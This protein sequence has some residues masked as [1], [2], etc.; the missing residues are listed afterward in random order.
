[1]S[2]DQPPYGPPQG[3]GQDPK[4]GP[5]WGPPQ[6]PGQQGWG[7]QGQPQQGWG[8]QGQG[9]P[10][11]GPQGYGQQG[12]AQQGGPQGHYGPGDQ[13]STAQQ[14][15]PP[16]RR[17][18]LW[19]GGAAA[20]TAVVLVGGGVFAFQQVLGGG[21]AQPAEAI[22]DTAVAY[23]R[24]DLDPSAG[25]KINILRLLN[26][27]PDFSEETGIDDEDADLRKVLFEQTLGKQDCDVDYEQ[28]V[29]P[30]I[31]D[32]AGVA[33][34]PGDG[35]EPTPLVVLQVT[36]RDAARDG[37]KALAACD[38][39]GDE[40]GYDFVGDYLL[41]ADS[42]RAASKAADDAEA[43][44]L[45]QDDTFSADMAE[46]GEQGVASAWGDLEGL[47]KIAGADADDLAL[48]KEQ[49][50]TSAALALR[51]GSD[52]IEVASAARVTDAASADTDERS[53][54]GQMP[55]DTVAAVGFAGGGKAVEQGWKAFEEA[56]A[57]TPGFAA[58]LDEIESG[59]GLSFPGD[60][61]TL[62]GDNLT[63][64][65]GERGLDGLGNLQDPSGLR[66]LDV[67]LRSVTDADELT[68]VIG[69]LNRLV[70]QAGVPEL[71]TKESDDGLVVATNDD[72]AGKLAEGGSLGDTDAFT[73]VVPD[74]DDAV[75]VLYVDADKV[76]DVV[77]SVGGSDAAEAKKY[78]DPVR[79][80]GFSVG[81]PDGDYTSGSL[82]VSFD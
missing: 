29:E 62:F 35:D 72:W 63:L 16:R 19:I 53:Q 36:D 46:L 54:V 3:W 58:D 25:Q 39:S 65:V 9:Q 80:I 51:A 2:N 48:A 70:G 20:A 6:Q 56:L 67:G 13:W 55:D 49:G 14:G 12:Y 60:L 10:G 22:P 47:A 23:A 37:V 21:G 79:A 41:V 59:T 8:Q 45:S 73:K 7:S 42:Q 40:T 30:W 77:G 43:S 24:I 15:P 64:A 17:K 28:D 26:R 34:L 71:V 1:M 18:G 31:G 57:G 81:A 66:S 38:G 76:S 4:Q 33:A 50:L 74:G 78:L 75:G 82:R 61:V 32:R 69:N 27:L 44:P 52:Y 68:S 11:W 5:Q